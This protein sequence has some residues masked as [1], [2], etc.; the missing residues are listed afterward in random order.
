M[1]KNQSSE[2]SIDNLTI[3]KGVFLGVVILLIL[4]AIMALFSGFL[5]RFNSSTLNN[6]L[7]IENFLILNTIGFYVARHVNKNGWLNGG[8]SGLVYMILLILIG[9]IS[10]PISIGNIILMALSGLVVGSIGGIIGINL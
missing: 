9:T 1:F 3:F 7:L 10:M 6:I 5:F 4:T 8:L 2:K